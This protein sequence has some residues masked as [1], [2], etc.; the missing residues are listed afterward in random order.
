MNIII[1]GRKQLKVREDLQ[2]YIETKFRKFEKIVLEPTVIEIMLADVR[3]PQKGL[4]KVVHLTATLPGR[5]NPEHIEELASGF[6]EAVDLVFE[7]FKKFISRWKEKNKEG[8]RYPR[9]YYFAEKI[10]K[11]SGEI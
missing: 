4:D 6:H 5:K 9:K 10:E 11:E 3:G 8:A 7:R 2:E 1:K